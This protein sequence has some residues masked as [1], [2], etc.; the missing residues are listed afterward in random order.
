[1]GFDSYNKK[2]EKLLKE[3]KITQEEYERMIQNN[4]SSISFVSSI[5]SV[6]SVWD[7]ERR[8]PATGLRMHGSVDAGGNSYS[9]SFKNAGTFDAT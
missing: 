4:K 8:N 1:M 9:C 2:Y 6:S 3:G 5:S 7:D